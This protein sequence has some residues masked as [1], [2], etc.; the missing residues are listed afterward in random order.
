[1]AI[2]ALC[3]TQIIVGMAEVDKTR[4][5]WCDGKEKAIFRAGT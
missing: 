3:P 4:R 1:V 5:R 2:A